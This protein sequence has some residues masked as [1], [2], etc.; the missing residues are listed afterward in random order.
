MAIVAFAFGSFVFGS[1]VASA[2]TVEPD[3]AVDAQGTVAPRLSLTE[4]QKSAIYNAVL[5]QRVRNSAAQVPAAVGALVPPA[6]ELAELPDQS[7][8]DPSSHPETR[9]LKYAMVQDDVVVID[10][11]NMRVVEVIHG[12][13][14][15]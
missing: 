9:D 6:V 5:A 4:A 10:A 14:N 3:E 11:V 13:I 7:A 1:T 15:R 8:D 12:G 2:Q